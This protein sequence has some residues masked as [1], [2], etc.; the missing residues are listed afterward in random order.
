MNKNER[1]RFITSYFVSQVIARL[2]N[3]R[4][5]AAEWKE[6]TACISFFF[7]NTPTEDELDE[8]SDV[9]TAVIATYPDGYLKENYITLGRDSSLP[10]DME[11]AYKNE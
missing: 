8:A 10:T 5:I 7:Y 1:L 11:W 3:L 2:P 4:A 6:N 9:C